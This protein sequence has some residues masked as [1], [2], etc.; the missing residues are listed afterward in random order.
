MKRMF[1]LVLAG[2]LL[3]GCAVYADPYPYAYSPPPPPAGVSVAPAPVV[4]APYPYWG[5]RWHNGYRGGSLVPA[6][7]QG[8][9][10]R[11]QYRRGLFM[12]ALYSAVTPKK[13]WNFTHPDEALQ[14]LTC[15]M[16][17][18]SFWSAGARR[19]AFM[20]GPVGDRLWPDI[21]SR[22]VG[23]RRAWRDEGKAA[24]GVAS[25]GRRL[26]CV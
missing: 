18:R 21:P 5:W 7:S 9:P 20:V 3:G 14:N 10:R 16:G 13:I 11:A 26:C 4:V 23:E 24:G 17:G 19:Y 15:L 2:L 8:G 22:R 1:G 25:P 12:F 6:G